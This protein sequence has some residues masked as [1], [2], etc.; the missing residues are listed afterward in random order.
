MDVIVKLAYQEEEFSQIFSLNYATFVEEIPQHQINEE[1]AL[2]DRFHN[3]NKY[4]IAL[5]HGE[6]VGM[7]CINDCRP[8]SLESKVQ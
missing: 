1:K 2:I 5:L 7:I 3:N 6:V 8:F 4:I